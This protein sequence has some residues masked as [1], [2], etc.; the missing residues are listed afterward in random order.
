[1][2]QQP[3]RLLYFIPARRCFFSSSLN[4]QEHAVGHS[5]GDDHLDQGFS[6]TDQG[7]RKKRVDL[8]EAGNGRLRSR[9]MDRSLE[10]AHPD[11]HI[12]I[13]ARCSPPRAEEDEKYRIGLRSEIDLARDKSRRRLIEPASQ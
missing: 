2:H 5:A 11:L 10:P 4:T 13:R 8:I 1:M 7:A 3:E 6:F 9:V 12:G